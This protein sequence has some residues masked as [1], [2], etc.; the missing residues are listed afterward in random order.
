MVLLRRLAPT[1]APTRWRWRLREVAARARSV[2][3]EVPRPWATPSVTKSEGYRT[4][5]QTCWTK[6]MSMASWPTG[7]SARV[8]GDRLAFRGSFRRTG[9]DSGG[10]RGSLLPRRGW[11]RSH[12]QAG[13]PTTVDAGQVASVGVGRAPA[14]SFGSRRPAMVVGPAG[15]GSSLVGHSLDPLSA[16]ER[17]DLGRAGRFGR[18]EGRCS[19]RRPAGLVPTSSCGRP[20]SRPA[21]ASDPGMGRGSGRHEVNPRPGRSAGFGS[22]KHKADGGRRDQ[23]V[24]CSWRR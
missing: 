22:G 24:W 21:P 9:G 4:T 5:R 7:P 12:G 10:R 17:G 3:A 6:A 19:R 14:R 16:V 15:L 1:A 18:G 11:P 13:D 8:G 2:L 20:R 23:R